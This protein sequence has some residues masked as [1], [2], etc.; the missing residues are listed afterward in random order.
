MK[1]AVLM[2]VYAGDEINNFLTAYHSIKNQIGF[3]PDSINVYLHV[4]GKI[5]NDFWKEIK[6]LDVFVLLQS[7]DSVGLASG[8]N[9]LIHALGN[10]NY[11]FR[12]D[13][14][15]ISVHDRFLQQ[16]RFMEDNT[17]VD[18]SGGSIS[19]FIGCDTNIVYKRS[20][21]TNHEEIFTQLPKSSPFAHVTVC[22]RRNIFKKI[23]VYPLEFGT[24]EDIAFW[25][26]A[27]SRGAITANIDT[28][29]CCVRMDGAY[30]R[31]SYKKAIGEFKVYANIARSRNIL[32]IYALAR[33]VFRLTPNVVTSFLYRSTLRNLFLCGRK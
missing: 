32:P 8:L 1:L 29:L 5:T 19:E 20:Y 28:L 14:D 6:A 12:M 4:D 31:R 30:E 26:S 10:E 24:N 22:F 27:L 17:N 13:S 11:I 9:K 15:D 18:F 3:S 33:L 16:V 21:P 2:C 23:G 25:H 7:P